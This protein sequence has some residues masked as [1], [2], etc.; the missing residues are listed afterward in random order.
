MGYGLRIS[1]TPFLEEDAETVGYRIESAIAVTGVTYGAGRDSIDESRTVRVDAIRGRVRPEDRVRGA[2][3]SWDVLLFAG[4]RS[5]T[6][7]FRTCAATDSTSSEKSSPGLMN[8]S[9]STWYCL[10]YNTR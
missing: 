4:Y 8:R 9:C 6:F 5:L 3:P 1:L 10:S 2:E 7:T